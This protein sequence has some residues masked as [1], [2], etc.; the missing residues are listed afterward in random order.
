MKASLALRESS[1]LAVFSEDSSILIS[2]DGSGEPNNGHTISNV[3]ELGWHCWRNPRSSANA[4][5]TMVGG[6]WFL[7]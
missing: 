2:I 1:I 4:K 6:G 3:G 7:E 5:F